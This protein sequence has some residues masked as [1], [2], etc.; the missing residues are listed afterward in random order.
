M[1]KYSFPTDSMTGDVAKE[2]PIKKDDHLPD[3]LRYILHTLEGAKLG[4]QETVEYYDP[5][6]IS[7]Y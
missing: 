3:C 5:V 4:A 6:I 7:P 1:E 2:N